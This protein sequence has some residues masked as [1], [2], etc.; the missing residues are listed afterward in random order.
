LK[1]RKLLNKRFRQN[2]RNE[3]ILEIALVTSLTAINCG[4]DQNADQLKFDL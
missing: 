4:I 2:S 1:F 3:L